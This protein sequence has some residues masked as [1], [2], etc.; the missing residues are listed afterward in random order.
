[1]NFVLVVRKY[2]K[3]KA[4]RE[5]ASRDEMVGFGNSTGDETPHLPSDSEQAPDLLDMGGLQQPAIPS[6]SS[7]EDTIYG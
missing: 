5:G 6:E 3:R 4:D 1:M 2:E 7:D